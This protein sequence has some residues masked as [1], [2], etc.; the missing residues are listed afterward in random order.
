M[1]PED[2]PR[3][4]SIRIALHTR[5]CSRKWRFESEKQGT[6][7]NNRPVC[8]QHESPKA[9]HAS[10]TLFSRPQAKRLI[11]NISQYRPFALACFPSV[12]VRYKTEIANKKKK[13]A[14][15]A[16][17]IGSCWIDSERLNPH[18]TKGRERRI[19]RK[20]GDIILRRYSIKQGL[21]AGDCR[22]PFGN[23]TRCSQALSQPDCD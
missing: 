4:H 13:K 6:A 12:Y 19:R 11:A 7:K 22:V 16:W 5:P 15:R 8:L 2:S 14:K 3:Q 18:G 17:P 21:L 23:Y 1:S 20:S 10:F 9:Q